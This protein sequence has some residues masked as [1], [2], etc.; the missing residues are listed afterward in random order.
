MMPVS[1]FSSGRL[2]RVAILAA[3]CAHKR[4]KRMQ[5]NKRGREGMSPKEK[6]FVLRLQLGSGN[7]RPLLFDR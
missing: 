4:V 2:T 3:I 1:R 7:E 6:C 5:K